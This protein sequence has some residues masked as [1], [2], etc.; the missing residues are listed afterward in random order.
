MQFFQLAQSFNSLFWANSNS[1]AMVRT[2]DITKHNKV[3]LKRILIA[4]QNALYVEFD[5]NTFH[6]RK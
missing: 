2:V 3:K 4:L 5:V 6:L 1:S